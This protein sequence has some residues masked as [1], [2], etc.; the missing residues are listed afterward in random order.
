VPVAAVQH[1]GHWARA[2]RGGLGT[3]VEKGGARYR[4]AVAVPRWWRPTPELEKDTT[5]EG[6]TVGELVWSFYSSRGLLPAASFGF[7]TH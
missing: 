2:V 3:D 1:A 4:R 5:A 6:A 7:I